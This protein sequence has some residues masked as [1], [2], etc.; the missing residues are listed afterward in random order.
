MKC[1]AAEILRGRQEQ[2]HTNLYSLLYFEFIDCMVSVQMIDQHRWAKV[3]LQRMYDNERRHLSE[4]LERYSS[5]GGRVKDAHRGYR[6]LTESEL[7]EQNIDFVQ[8]QIDSHLA[9]FGF[10]YA[11]DALT[12]RLS[13]RKGRAAGKAESARRMM[14]Y[15]TGGSRA[16]R[17]YVTSLMVYLHDECGFGAERIRKIFEPVSAEMRWYIEKLFRTTET[18]D[19]ELKRRIDDAHKRIEE[20]GLVLEQVTVG[21]VVCAKN[22]EQPKEIPAGLESLAWDKI[23]DNQIIAERKV[24]YAE[25][26]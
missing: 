21:D 7:A 9:S 2:A 5:E 12:P 15:C 20:R 23:K 16:S 22:P 26:D 6:D 18:D 8:E 19:R 10:E 24:M 25:S 3:R 1:K 14:W 17:L 4:W 11:S 13:L